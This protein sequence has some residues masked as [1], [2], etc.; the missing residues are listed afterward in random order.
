[1]VYAYNGILFR[2]KKNEI[3]THTPKWMNL[4]SIMLS[5]ISQTQNKKHFPIYTAPD[6]LNFPK[7][8]STWLFLPGLRLSIVCLIFCFKHLWVV[9]Q[10]YDVFKQCLPFSRPGQVPSMCNRDECPSS[11]IQ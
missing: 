8:H 10:P 9:H 1:M 3:L 7:K 11:V 6:N 4:K 2:L 5:Q